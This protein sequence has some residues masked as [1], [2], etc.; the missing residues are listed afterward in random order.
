MIILHILIIFIIINFFYIFIIFTFKNFLALI[1]IKINFFFKK[2]LKKKNM[3]T[4]LAFWSM[5]FDRILG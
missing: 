4:S 2:K 5:F 3:L 1:F